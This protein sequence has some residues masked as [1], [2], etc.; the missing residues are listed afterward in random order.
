MARPSPGDLVQR[1]PWARGANNVA[2]Q[3]SIPSSSVRALINGDFYPGGKIRRRYGN[4]RVAAQPRMRNGWSDGHYALGTADGVL[5][6]FIPGQPLKQ[7]LTGLRVDADVAYCSVNQYIRVS[8]G[9]EAWRVNTVDDT[10]VPW[11]VATPN[12]QPTLTATTIG[13]MDAGTYQLALTFARADGEEGG[14]TLST[15]VDVLDGGGIALSDFPIAP[16]DVATI[17]IYLTPP[18]G[19]EESLYAVV[20]ANATS[21]QLSRGP[22]GRALTTQLLSRIPPGTDMALANGVL[23][24]IDGPFLFWS[25][26]LQFGLYS[27]ERNYVAYASNTRMVVPTAQSVQAQGIFVATETSTY[28]EQ[29]TDPAKF[30][31]TIAYHASAIPNSKVFVPGSFFDPRDQIP[32]I[33]VPVWVAANGTV[34]VG[35]PDGTVKTMTEGKFAMSV[36]DRGAGVVRELNG[37]RQLLF[38]MRPPVAVSRVAARDSVTITRVKNGIVVP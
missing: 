32:T 33:P 13:A 30:N 15:S 14:A 24:V 8:D 21:A 4:E 37:I 3:D 6:R 25:E 12:R 16:P 27:P 18:N 29:G 38:S 35:M 11:G 31:H 19:K 1:G 9:A 26:Y 17:Q 10:V 36:G 28:F 23:F 22:Y 2:R 34:C 5:Y 20:P 7:L